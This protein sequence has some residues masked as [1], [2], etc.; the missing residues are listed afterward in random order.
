V[1]KLLA[2]PGEVIP[3]ALQLRL[4]FMHPKNRCIHII[5]FTLEIMEIHGAREIAAVNRPQSRRFATTGRSQTARS[6]W[7]AAALAPL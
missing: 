7:T 2:N 3:A 6:V 1:S 4:K 5:L